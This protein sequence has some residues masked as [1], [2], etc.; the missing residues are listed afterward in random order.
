MRIYA[1]TYQDGPTA[2]PCSE[3]DSQKNNMSIERFFGFFLNFDR[4]M[5]GNSIL[6][7]NVLKRLKS[8]Q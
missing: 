4:S 6:I 1:I 7:E 8:T 3:D 5:S 2:Q